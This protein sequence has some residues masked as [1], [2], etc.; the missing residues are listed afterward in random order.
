[1]MPNER[2]GVDAGWHVLFAFQRPRSGVAAL[3]SEVI[4]QDIAVRPDHNSNRL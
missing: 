3:T 2:G 4:W 1:M